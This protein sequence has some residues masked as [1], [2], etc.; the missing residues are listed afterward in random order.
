MKQFYKLLI[1]V[2]SF[3][4]SFIKNGSAQTFLNGDF[5]INTAG[6]DQINLGNAAFN[7]FMSNTVAFGSFG[8]MDIISSATYCGLA[9]NGLWYVAFTGSGTDAITMQLSAPLT[10]GT[11][12]TISYWDRGCF[13]TFATT[14]PAVEIG[15]SNTAGTFGT[16]VYVAPLPT[17]GVWVNRTFTFT[18]P[19]A[20]AFITVQLPAGG[21]GD[22][23][24][25]DNFTFVTTTLTPPVVNFSTSDNNICVGD[26]ISFTDLTTNSPT[27]WSWSFPGGTPASSSVQ[28]PS[29]ICYATAGTYPVTLTA[30][31]ASGSDTLTQ[32]SFITVNAADNA[33]FNYSATAYCQSGPNPTPT[34]TGTPGGTFTSSGGLSI[35]GSTGTINLLGSTPGT[36]TV[37]YTTS[38][39]C[40][41]TS[42]ASVT[43][44]P[45]SLATFSYAGPY[46]QNATDPSPTLG[47]GAVAGTFTSAPGLVINASNG[48][49]DVSASTAGTYTVTNTT[50]TSGSCPAA[51]ATATITINS[52]PIPVVTGNSP[53]CSGAFSILTAA[54][55][56]TYLWNTGATTSSITVSP[57]ITT[58][59]T[60]TAN[61]AGCT[62]TSTITIVVNPPVTTTANPIICQGSTYTLPSGTTVSTAGVYSDTLNTIAG[63]DSVINTTLTVTPPPVGTINATICS[64]QTYTLPSGTT[65][66][67]AGTYNSTVTTSG[68]C[69]SIVTTILT[70]TPPP[71]G[72]VADTICA[73]QSYTLPDG[74]S[75]GNSGTYT[76]TISAAGGCD[77]IV[78]TN[79]TVNTATVSAGA[80]VVIEYGSSTLLTASGGITYSWSPAVGLTTTSGAN[81]TASP[82]Q[83][84]VYTVTATNANGC[85]ATDVVTVFV[86]LPPCEGA[87]VDLKTL[88]PNAFSPNDD[89]LND[90][91][92]IPENP[93]I[94]SLTLVIYDRWGE[95]VYEGTMD[96]CWDSTYRGK[97]LDTAVFAYHFTVV[98][99][100]G[101]KGNGKGNIS[102][103]K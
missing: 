81:T 8:D 78:V 28:N 66:G 27:A 86:D 7:G 50:A 69:D 31:N 5:E 25:V 82:T 26:C 103:I 33:A 70:V 10:V 54:G 62:A 61:S 85:T 79:L 16:P 43:I 32:T 74:S 60:V 63:C 56:S 97:K 84:T 39:A 36:Y 101:T 57:L 102:L 99:A 58:S 80:D 9:Q 90:Q 92:C 64:G 40:P 4:F 73:G 13:G 24:Q 22:W 53:I 17:N 46:C 14:S 55:G 77:S 83:T 72:I 21:L 6:V 18:A 52:V 68:G 93:C 100:D 94:V 65:T 67:T 3:H 47:A 88:I 59:Y 19:V 87:A 44:D 49:V 42:T 30:I 2:I 41:A 75:V 76:D 89:G 45:S 95:K 51:T 38:G 1:I 35:T 96:E 71:V 48:V 91:L 15:V 34:I 23:T 20:G 29:S 98:F 11:S 37:T 12:Y